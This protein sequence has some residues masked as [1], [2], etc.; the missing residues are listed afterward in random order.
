MQRR[1]NDCN[2]SKTP[3]LH[4]PLSLSLSLSLSLYLSPSLGIKPSYLST[5]HVYKQKG[6]LI[7]PYTVIQCA[8]LRHSTD[9]CKVMCPTKTQHR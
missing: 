8:P 4:L 5:Y 6:A 9:D 2:K 7:N 3:P 1:N